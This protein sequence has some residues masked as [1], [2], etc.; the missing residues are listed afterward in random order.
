M[1]TLLVLQ[2]AD[3]IPGTREPV[4]TALGWGVVIVLAA[5]FFA[6]FYLLRRR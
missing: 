3:Q 4:F 6:A 2:T 5:V 1:L